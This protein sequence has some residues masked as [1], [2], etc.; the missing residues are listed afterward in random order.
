MGAEKIWAQ[1]V[2][3]VLSMFSAGAVD[4]SQRVVEK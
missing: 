2:N 4:H 3:A 1:G